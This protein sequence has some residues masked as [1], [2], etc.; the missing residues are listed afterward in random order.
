MQEDNAKILTENMKN[1][2]AVI[3]QQAISNSENTT[4]LYNSQA[5]NNGGF[6]LTKYDH[7]YVVKNEINT[8]TLDSYN[9]NNITLIKI[10]VEA[11]ELEVLMGAKETI[12][13]N[14]PVIF[15]EDLS[16]GW[17]HMFESN[18]FDS[19]FKSVGY[20]QAYKNLFD[21]LMDCWLPID[22]KKEGEIL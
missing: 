1:K 7:S 9:F 15:V 14:K 19:F 17:P 21:E 3:Y 5:N 20:F 13:R 10:D 6:S 8:R 4:V 18:R 11:H 2:N 22:Y 16:Y 12:T